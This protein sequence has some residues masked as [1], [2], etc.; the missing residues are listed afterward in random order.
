LI[1]TLCA[2]GFAQDFNGF[3]DALTRGRALQAAKQ[4]E[5]ALHAFEFAFSRA[6]SE[7]ESAQ[8][9]ARIGQT[10]AEL[11]KTREAIEYMQRSLDF[12]HYDQVEQQLKELR[13]QLLSKVQTSDEI[14]AALRDQQAS[15]RSTRV[16]PRRPLALQVN[17]EFNK[18]DLT[19]EGRQQVD[20]LGEALAQ[21]R[22]RGI[23]MASKDER[24]RITGHTDLVGKPEY[25]QALSEQRAQAV[26]AE[27]A[28]RFGLPLSMMVTEGKGMREPLYNSTSPEDSRLNRRVEVTVLKPSEDST[29]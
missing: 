8:A 27:I 9:T 6:G 22:T 16:M 10:L 7:K 11:G 15:N 26:A 12:Y 13:V 24:I 3:G 5:Q 17:F 2:S 18:A 14:T 19:D 29:Q 20:L 25:N 23:V 1:A 28:A 21:L 4:Y